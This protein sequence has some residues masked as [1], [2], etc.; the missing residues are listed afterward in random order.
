MASEPLEPA[1]F[2]RRAAG[3]GYVVFSAWMLGTRCQERA[4]QS[5]HGRGGFREGYVLLASLVFV[6]P[7]GTDGIVALAA[8]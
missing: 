5:G 1:C 2:Q 8:C 3:M 6:G 7:L 4:K